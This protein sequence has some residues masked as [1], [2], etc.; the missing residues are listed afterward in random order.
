MVPT[1]FLPA[2][3]LA[4]GQAPEG[5]AVV[6]GRVVD[7]E[8]RPARDVET[9]LTGG[10]QSQREPS[11][12][13]T[14]AQ[15]RFRLSLPVEN[16]PVSARLPLAVWAYAPQLGFAGRSFPRSAIPAEANLE[17]KLFGPAQARV[18]VEGSEG[19][20]MDGATV[21][22]L[23]VRGIGGLPS[24]SAFPLPDVLAERFKASVGAD[25]IGEIRGLPT[26]VV[27]T[28][29]VDAA[30]FGHQSFEV[31]T[32]AGAI[33]SIRLKPVGRLVGRVATEDPK[34][35]GGLRVNAF[36]TSAATGA[37]DSAYG[38]TTTDAAGRF[39][40][41]ALAAGSLRVNVVSPNPTKLRPRQIPNLRIDAGKTTEV[42]VPME[43]PPRLRSIAGRVVGRGGEPVAGAI[44]FQ[45][46]DSPERTETVCDAGGKFV[47]SGV[48]ARPTYVFVRKDG[49]RFTG[50]AVA[51]EAGDLN[52]RI[53]RANEPPRRARPKLAPML[54]H[55]EE[56]ALARRLLD[57]YAERALKEGGEAEHAQ[58]LRAL[59]RIEP[60]RVLDLIEKKAIKEPLSS[61]MLGLAVARG[62]MDE[63]L[64]EALA[65]LEGLSDPAAKAG[66]YIEA[67]KRLP[68][69]G[70][71]K[72][73]D[74]LERALLSARAI[75]E[76]DGVRLALTGRIAERFLDLGKT[77]RG[78]ALLRE[79]EPLARQ[80]PKAG[81]AGYAR[82]AF[83]E[84]LAQVD[85]T[86]A[87]ALIADLPD[88]RELDRHRGN[89]AHELAGRDPA[90]AERV[91]AMVTQ[92][93]ERDRYAPRVVYRMAPVDHARAGRIALAV[94]DMCLRGFALGMMAQGL[95]EAGEESAKNV[96]EDAMATLD[97]AAL[98]PEPARRSLYNAAP[99]AAALLPVA[100]R[101]DPQLV[102]E[103]L[104]RAL[105]I[106]LPTPWS[107]RPAS[108][109]A[110]V[111][112]QL[113]TMIARY[114]RTIARS[115]I[116][117]HAQQDGARSPYEGGLGR[118]QVAAA[119][120]DPS[121]AVTL[122]EAM[123]DDAD[124]K[125]LQ[126]KN[127]ARLAVSTILGRS[128]EARWRTLQSEYL[129]LWVAD[130]EDIDPDL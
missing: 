100:E 73:L 29:A 25:G 102:D 35:A 93:Y 10:A 87:L 4:L 43:S 13:R 119:M 50:L 9:L 26:G 34:A 83:A 113:A 120:V 127:A 85:L 96:F 108:R 99:V 47:L 33:A 52:V 18:R 20:P 56:L 30:G 37:L 23:A 54:P 57:P 98:A 68:R 2:I 123:P 114:D 19:R 103:T 77:E 3:L 70:A 12:T 88:A 5:P 11:Q 124:L 72:A 65:V 59:A 42:T 80:C 130:V 104:W 128:G 16:N 91:L 14:D 89:I 76:P 79:E 32:D 24:S 90:H 81:M 53:H 21:T 92:G 45:S 97:R 1:I 71:A 67:S 106:R 95:A 60:E 125:T 78:Q 86:A 69:D 62:L 118:L 117:P 82:G 129:H 49:Y 74:M 44:V 61:S 101:I 121:W 107:Y 55:A 6:A 122:I 105:A 27:H 115:L 40:I 46:G 7:A 110:A 36:T 17:L 22:P 58:T 38:T 111:D 41:P 28:V 84:E 66:G 112:V 75:K 39:E 48:V 51:A 94:D 126:P 64:D 8:G 116:E 15:G 109:A 31:S 63:S